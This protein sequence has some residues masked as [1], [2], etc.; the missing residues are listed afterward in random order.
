MDADDAGD[1]HNRTSMGC[2]VFVFRGAAVSWSS[3]CIR[4][5]TLS[6][7]ESEN[8]AATDAGMEGRRLR[9][10]LAKFLQLDAGTLT[11]LRVDNKSA[12]TVAKGMEL[13]GN[14][15]HMERRQAWLQHMVKS[16]KFSLRYIPTAEQPADFLTRALHYPAFNRCSVAISQM[17]LV[18]L[19]D[20]DND[21]QR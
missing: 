5:A 3:Q 13:T 15:K 7:T 10:L 17:R 1:K 2:Y 20:G 8:V 14:L 12:I 21:V 11:V 4:C 19:G 6:S 9:F 16:R 18:N